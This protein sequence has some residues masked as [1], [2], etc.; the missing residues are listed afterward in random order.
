MYRTRIRF[1]G[2]DKNPAAVRRVQRR[3]ELA[4]DRHVGKLRQ[5]TATFS[6]ENGPRGGRDTRCVLHVRLNAGGPP[7]V[8]RA[9]E[10]TPGQAVAAAL[11]HLRRRL[12]RRAAARTAA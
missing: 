7:I 6:D 4:L 11:E 2:S 9:V 1:V 12:D 5:V 10:E 3:I 8:V